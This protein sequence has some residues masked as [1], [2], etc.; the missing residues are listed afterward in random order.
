MQL[1][2]FYQIQVPKPWNAESEFK[3]YWEVAEEVPH[4]EELG[5]ESVWFVEHH[6]RSEWSHSSAPEMMLSALSQRTSRMQLGIAVTL[7]PIHHPLNVASRMAVLDIMSKGRANLGIGRSGYPYQMAAFGKQLEDARGMMFENIDAIP[8]AWTQELFSYEGKYYQI[9]EREVIPKPIQKPHPPM[10]LACTQLETAQWAGE[11][12]LG[13]IVQASIGPGAPG[14]LSKMEQLITTYREA[15]KK[16]KPPAGLVYNK[17]SGNT[18]AFCH[19][20]REK[21]LERGAEL[22]DWYREQQRIRDSYVWRGVDAS[23]VPEDY[24]FHYE[25]SHVDPARRDDTSSLDLIKQGGRF[26]IGNPDD[27]IQYLEQ[28]EAMGVDEIMPLFQV[29]PATHEEVVNSLDLFGKYIIPHFQEKAKK[30]QA[31]AATADG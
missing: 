20:N 21:A 6:F 8:K 4:A 30:S 12:G 31:A 13:A 24:K 22:I 27:C 18:V 3:R 23:E 19:E 17:V 26:C 16:A 29:G 7:A 1:G 11:L 5:F 14:E 9:P 28:C 2:L 10:W 25:R 15:I